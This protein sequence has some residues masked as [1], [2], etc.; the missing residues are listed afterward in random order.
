MKK[1]LFAV[2]AVLILLAG[3]AFSQTLAPYITGSIQTAPGAS[4]Q[5]YSVG[6]GLESNTKYL[7]LDANGSYNSANQVAG[8]GHSGTLTA[9]GYYKFFGHFLAGGGATLLVTTSGFSVSNF[10]NTAR[11]SANPFVGGGLYFG[12]FR[13][14]ATYQLP[15]K[16]ALN[17]QRFFN[18]DNEISMTKHVRVVVP[19]GINSYINGLSSRATVAQVGGGLKFVF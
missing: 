1:Y 19:L 9:Q 12:R 18:V 2:L 6:V 14:I 13:S 17:G 11:E 10:I 4:N 16:D 8:A 3:S 5:N 7:L 15:G